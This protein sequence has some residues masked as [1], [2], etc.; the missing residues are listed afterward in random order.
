VQDGTGFP[1]ENLAGRGRPDA[2]GA[3]LKQH[4]AEP[5]LQL[6]DLL[7]QSGLRDMDDGSRAGKTA[8]VD[9]F[10]KIP[11]LAKLHVTCGA[12]RL[13]IIIIHCS[14]FFASATAGFSGS[15]DAFTGLLLA[16]TALP[17]FG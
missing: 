6:G 10:N 8:G 17:T 3:A 5:L 14:R 16:T 2:S 11:E 13:K 9:N 4:D 12:L 15:R 7:A 1:V